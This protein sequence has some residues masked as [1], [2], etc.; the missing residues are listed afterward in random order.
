MTVTPPARSLRGSFLRSAAFAFSISGMS[1]LL[2]V[3]FGEAVLIAGVT[4]AIGGGAT[5][6]DL[7]RGSTWTA[8]SSGRDPSV[9]RDLSWLAME[10]AG[11]EGRTTADAT[12]YLSDLT[13][14]RLSR[15]GVKM[16]QRQTVESL[17]GPLAYSVAI[18]P[19]TLP[20][21]HVEFERCVQALERL[22]DPERGGGRPT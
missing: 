4:L 3:R 19:P 22:D 7:E 20:L 17:I 14:R 9:R 10:V 6:L 16:S 2:G 13:R 8:L 15:R 21:R 5:R 11:T 18:E 1:W 12:G